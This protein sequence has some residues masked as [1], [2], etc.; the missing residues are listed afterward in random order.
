MTPMAHDEKKEIVR[1]TKPSHVH[2]NP[3]LTG[4][5]H[6]VDVQKILTMIT[7]LKN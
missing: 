7:Q 1:V 4:R 2:Q 6:V 3:K 5:L